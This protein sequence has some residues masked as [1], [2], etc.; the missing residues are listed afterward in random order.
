[1][2][3]V[4]LDTNILHEEGLN[5]TRVQRIQR[6]IKSNDLKLIVPEI[7]INEFKSKRIEQA[8]SDLDKI[9]S[10]L[11]S[12]QRKNITVKDSFQIRQAID[13]ISSSIKSCN[14]NVD[15]WM[16]ENNVTIYKISNTSIDELFASYFSGTGAFRGKKKRED[17]PDA[18]IYDGIVK[19]SEDTKLAVVCK[20]GVLLKAISKL[21][22]VESYSSL[23]ELL[24][25]L[26]LKERI[27]E[28]DKDESKVKSILEAL[29]TFDCQYNISNYLEENK[30]VDVESCYENDFIKL[31]Y[32]FED[33]EISRKEV[34]VKSVGDIYLSSPN[35][36]GNKKFS[37]TM[38]IESEAEFS[39]YCEDEQYELLPYA[40]RK[41]LTKDLTENGGEIYVYG[42]LDVTLQGVLVIENVDENTDLSELKLHLSYLGADRCEIECALEIES[43]K[44]NE[45]Y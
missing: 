7:V 8:N 14:D 22:N 16:E 21:K 19:I 13:F 30:I 40:Y 15:I 4:L 11:D 6:L 23:S 12:L 37:L 18:V 24:E 29:D 9:Q 31:P 28:L 32:D 43:A 20:D 10:G 38:D 45:I 44:V 42:A 27:E 3:N 36:L 34:K 25:L 2:L 35:Y 17:I 39:F 41:V 1:M 5:S 26:L 33:I